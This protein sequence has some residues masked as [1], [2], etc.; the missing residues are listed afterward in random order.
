MGHGK[1]SLDY[2]K[3]FRRKG[4]AKLK[5]SFQ[6]KYYSLQH[7]GFWDSARESLSDPSS[8]GEVLH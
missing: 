5:L 1:F 7:G 8:I 3:T 6:E 2:R 4:A